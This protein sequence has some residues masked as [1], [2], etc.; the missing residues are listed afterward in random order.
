MLGSTSVASRLATLVV[1]STGSFACLALFVTPAGGTIPSD[2]CTGNPCVVTS[3]VVV[4][5]GS[6]LTFSGQSLV[7]AANVEVRVGAGANPRV[8]TLIADDILLEPGAKILGDPSAGN[9]SDG[10]RAAVTLQSVVGDIVLQSSGP[11]ISAIDVRADAIEAGSITLT[12]ANDALL[13]GE[14]IA[15]ANGE[16]A[17]GGQITVTASGSIVTGEEVTARGQGV[18]AG[19]GTIHLDA[20][21]DIT[22][23]D[24]LTTEGEEFGGGN[25]E[26]SAIGS[27]VVADRIVLDG[28]DPDGDA[29]QL[30]AVAG[31]DITIASSGRLQ[32]A[33]GAGPDEDCGDGAKISLDAGR[34]IHMHGDVEVPG[35]F[36]CF[37]GDQEYDV[38]LDFVQYPT[39]LISTSTG[40]PFGASGLVEIIAGRSATLGDLDLSAA[41]FASDAT[42]VA[43]EFIDV[44]D[45]ITVRGT[46]NPESI[47][48]S[49]E[50]QSCTIEIQPA[51]ELDARS[52]F[53]FN[54]FGSTRLK[55]SGVATVDG[56]VRAASP[57]A[58]APNVGNFVFYRS[59]PPVVNG[60]VVPAEVSTLD[61][62]L[63]ECGYCGDGIVQASLGEACDDGGIESCDGC[64]GTCERV[65]AICGDGITEC[66]E[67][68]DDGNNNPGDGCEP[69]CGIGPICGNGV[70]DVGEI[71]DDGNLVDG[72]CCSSDCLQLS[73]AGTVCRAS[74]GICDSEEVCD[75]V[76]GVCPVDQKSLAECRPSAGVCD[77]P[78]FCDG[79][80]DECPADELLTGDTCR[81]SA[82]PCDVAEACDGVMPEC[83]SDEKSAAVCRPS[84][85]ACDLPESCD[86]VGNACPP[87]E[88]VGAG[89]ECRASTGVCDPAEECDGTTNECG[90][91][92]TLPD[93]DADGACDLI[94]VCPQD[95]DPGQGD[96]DGD[97]LGDV[98]DPC[99]AGA[100]VYAPRLKITKFSTGAGDDKFK[101]K[102]TLVFDEMPEFDPVAD[103]ISIHVHDA[104]RSE[105][106]RAHVPG[107]VF[108]SVSRVG[109]KAR[110]DGRR[111]VFKSPTLVNGLVNKVT[112]AQTK[113]GPNTLKLVISGSKGGFASGVFELPLASTVALRPA[114]TSGA[115]ADVDFSGPAP[116]P[117]CRYS[118]SGAALV[119]R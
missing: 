68:C 8:M 21:L 47:G 1:A 48:G 112:I 93:G 46:G 35:G 26:L 9:N 74:A 25:I 97:G 101:L 29:G 64:S 28:G 59:A 41:G 116:F 3:N 55:A 23:E 105:I 70:L 33:G 104:A 85:G 58:F 39:S 76:S 45:K 57:T 4:D 81:A 118:A 82:G 5:A 19:G 53:V 98:C 107:G 36:E 6:V 34:D 89:V 10:D 7:I 77:T 111:Y 92:V 66:G 80:A 24:R 44:F 94:D 32:G 18:F 72:D 115:C 79:A 110:P 17:T 38:R 103:G 95:A 119:C 56:M 12:A 50:L 62:T 114:D 2:L 40:G 14:L 15:T 83:P 99:N 102:G 87:D 91:D 60:T 11:T 67:E 96:Q 100:E 30:T 75:G 31:G 51:G 52:N 78:E 13:D 109:W 90:P 65:D 86:G 69:G 37:G 106:L 113:F 108:D 49:I 73:T 54:G 27:I 22:T 42:I 61:A 71:C 88:L 117:T 16:D 84:S 20:G 43:P 63:P